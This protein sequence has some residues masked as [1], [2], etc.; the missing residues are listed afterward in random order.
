MGCVS[1]RDILLENLQLILSTVVPSG[2]LGTG[3]VL[4]RRRI[5]PYRAKISQV[6]VA[7]PPERS[8]SPNAEVIF[9]LVLT[10]RIITNVEAACCTIPGSRWREVATSRPSPIEDATKFKAGDTIGPVDIHA[11]IRGITDG[12]D[13]GR[14]SADRGAFKKLVEREGILLTL[15]VTDGW[16]KT[17]RVKGRM[18]PN[19]AP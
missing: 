11:V 15:K 4:M 6:T 12:A 1:I 17:W 9:T 7:C 16:R 10:P 8:L 13:A 19:A 18:R 3:V 2:A 14:R 5:W